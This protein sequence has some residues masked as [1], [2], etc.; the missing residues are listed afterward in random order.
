MKMLTKEI[1]KKFENT[2]IGTNESLMDAK[3]LV[4]YF[5][6]YGRGTW[7]ITEAERDGDDWLCYGYMNIFE[8]EAGYIMLSEILE[9]KV[10]VFGHELPLERDMY[11][12]NVTLR[13]AL[14]ID[15]NGDAIWE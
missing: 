1:E 5:N 7:Y 13:E 15:G 3:V 12:G 14:K 8:W 11:L 10:N 4:K 2:P 6:P 9:A